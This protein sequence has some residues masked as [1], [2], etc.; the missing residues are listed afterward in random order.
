MIIIKLL[1]NH[2]VVGY[3]VLKFIISDIII[4]ICSLIN[5]MSKRYCYTFNDFSP[6][7]TV[8]FLLRLMSVF[9]DDCGILL[10]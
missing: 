7:V 5:S 1:M 3:A 2:C 9:W 8:A 4:N 6:T 10:S